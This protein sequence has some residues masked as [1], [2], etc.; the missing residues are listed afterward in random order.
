VKE[1]AKAR[2]REA[3]RIEGIA[4]K[5]GIMNRCGKGGGFVRGIDT[6]VDLDKGRSRIR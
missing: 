6:E 4:S 1:A 3:A 5:V 2:E